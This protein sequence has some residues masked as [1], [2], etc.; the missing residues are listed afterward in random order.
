VNINGHNEGLIVALGSLVLKT[1]RL[2]VE[3]RALSLPDYL[4]PSPRYEYLLDPS[5]LFYFVDIQTAIPTCG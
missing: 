3:L 5:F 4:S 1:G 2:S